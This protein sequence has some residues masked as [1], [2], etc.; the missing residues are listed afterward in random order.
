LVLSAKFSI[1]ECFWRVAGC[2]QRRIFSLGSAEN[3]AAAERGGVS[4]KQL[5]F[6][7]TN[8][9]ITRFLSGDGVAEITDFMPLKQPGVSDHEHHLI[10][11]V[12][13]VRGILAF[14]MHCRPA[15]NYAR[16]IHELHLAEQ[17]A[18][19]RS[20]VLTL[21]LSSS[22][23]LNDDGK[24]GAKALFTLSEDQSAYFFLDSSQEEHLLPHPVSRE[25]Y[26][27]RFVET[28]RYWRRWLGQCRY[29][30]AGASMCNVPR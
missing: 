22:V 19:F 12:H 15:F 5:Y 28:R 20:P 6:P 17:G 25:I 7:E 8:I 16:D 9:L 30:G 1:T 29:Q 27:T 2:R 10:R 24:G 26:E 14:E 23:P 11:A 4:T 21:A 18:V 13:M 3:A